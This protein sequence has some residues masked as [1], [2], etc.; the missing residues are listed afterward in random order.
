[1]ADARAADF[2][3]VGRVSVKGGKESFSGGVQ[4]RHTERGD[5]ILL[6]SPLGQTLAQIQRRPEGVYLTTAEQ[7][8]YY[9]ADVESLTDQVL[10][11]R[12]P[13]MG[14]QYWVQSMN[15]PATVSAI[16]LDMDGRVMAIR[17]DGWEIGYFG[18]P[19]I[20]PVQTT[21]ARTASPRLLML[22][23]DGLQIKLVIDDWD[24]GTH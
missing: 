1:M 7:E 12:L 14:L 11:W 19:P 24:A 16:D 5:E 18:Y 4:W 9:A 8:S 13:L 21:Q 6:L 20:V 23:R 10:G 22:K 15:S 2:G 17:Q 3:L